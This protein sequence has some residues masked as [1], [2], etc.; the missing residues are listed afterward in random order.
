MQGTAIDLLASGDG[1]PVEKEFGAVGIGIFHR[2]CVEVLVDIHDAFG[3][4]AV[5]TAAQGL[6]LYG[7]LVLHPPQLID[8]VDVEVVEAAA[9]GPD[10]TVEA[11]HLIQEVGDA[12]WFWERGEISAR[13][14]HPVAP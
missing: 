6:R 4:G 5:L 1:A 3:T 14:V 7:P 9:A 10:E 11:L 2:V 8:Q 13:A 12:G